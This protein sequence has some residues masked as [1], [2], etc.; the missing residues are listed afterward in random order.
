[1]QGNQPHG[2]T[3]SQSMNLAWGELLKVFRQDAAAEDRI[4]RAALQ[5]EHDAAKHQQ[6]NDQIEGHV[7]GQSQLVT[8]QGRWC[9]EA[10]AHDD[11]TDDEQ[12]G[13]SPK[14]TVN[15]QVTDF[16][17]GIGQVSQHQRAGNKQEGDQRSSQPASEWRPGA[18]CNER[19]A[20]KFPESWCEPIFGIAWRAVLMTW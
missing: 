7:S 14:Q 9:R 17:S 3:G 20:W 16:G 6:K 2:Q 18:W 1:M 4:K 11:A 13:Q 10:A 12:P 19:L 15:A 5:A 8:R